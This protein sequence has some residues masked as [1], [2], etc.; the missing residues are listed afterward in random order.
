LKVKIKTALVSVSDKTGLEELV[1]CLAKHNIQ[2][3]S[4]GGTS[5]SIQGLG[6]AVND[7]SSITNFPEMMDG[8]VKTLHPNIHGGLLAKRDNDKHKNSQ[9]EHGIQDIDLVVVNLYP[10]EETI[11]SGSSD[12]KCIENIDIGGPAMLRSAAKNYQFVTV[13]TDTNDYQGLISE[14]NKNDGSTTLE[15]RKKL[16]AK[17]YATTAQ[18]DTLISN[19]FL[20]DNNELKTNF[21]S[22]STLSSEL[23]YGENPHQSAGIYKSSFQK[24][25]IPYANLIQGKELSYNNIN[26]ADAAL[27]LIKEFDS[28]ESAVA[29]IKHANPCGVACGQSLVDAYEKAFSCDTTSAFGGIIAVNQTLDE[30]TAKKIIEIFTEVIIV[31]DIT[32]GAKKLLQE[33]NNIRVLVINNMNDSKIN[34]SFKSIEG[35]I[36]VQSNDNKEIKDSDLKVVTKIQPTNEQK[37]D[38]L[39]AFKVCKHV[40]SNAIIYV[41]NKKTIGIGAGQMSRVDS[42]KIASQKNSE[43]KQTKENS[44]KD[45]IVASDAFFPFP[46]GLLVTISSGAT[47]VIQPGGSIKDAEVIKAADEAGISMIFTGTRHFKH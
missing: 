1:N 37:S 43:M 20:K 5:K 31:P 39:F 21:L 18:Y 34:Y 24:S 2:I 27:Q 6:A 15:F 14:L 44:L 12:E 46:D 42:A 19:W 25:G 32:E 28:K 35:G 45:S 30:D 38:M 10:F 4:T 7:V 47:A 11:D 16:A 33:K 13:V 36:L 22:P 17:T 40:K 3:I 8:R 41:K 29:I 9:K 26:D 23:R